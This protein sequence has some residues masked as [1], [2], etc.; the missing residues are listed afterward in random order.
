ARAASAT[1]RKSTFTPTDMLGASTTGTVRAAVA[2]TSL[3]AADRP[4]VPMTMAV[5]VAAA[6][7]A[8][9]TLAAGAEKS[10]QTS[11]A[12]AAGSAAFTGIGFD[13]MNRPSLSANSL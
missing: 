9:A 13:S 10:I 2:T 3:S 5:P 6:A 7:R 1:R 8:L 4:V 12:P 11:A